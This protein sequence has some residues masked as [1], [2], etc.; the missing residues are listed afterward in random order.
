M[1]LLVLGF[2]RSRIL[3]I[4]IIT[5]VCSVFVIVPSLMRDRFCYISKNCLK[6]VI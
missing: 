4:I 3:C 5:L 2:L 1:F 6:N